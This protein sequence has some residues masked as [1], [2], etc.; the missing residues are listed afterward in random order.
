ML[1]DT[2]AIKKNVIST[3]SRLYVKLHVYLTHPTVRVNDHKLTINE[4]EWSEKWMLD[5]DAR[6]APQPSMVADVANLLL[7]KRGEGP[8]QSDGPNWVRCPTRSSRYSKL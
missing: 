1:P 4:E 2:Y 8:I 6:G 7:T 5:M 3:K